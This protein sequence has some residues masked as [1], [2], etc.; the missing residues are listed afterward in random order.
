MANITHLSVGFVVMGTIKPPSTTCGRSAMG[1]SAMAAVLDETTVESK[2]PT[3]TALT[4]VVMST[5][6][7]SKNASGPPLNPNAKNAMLSS[8][9]H[10]ITQKNAS[11]KNLESK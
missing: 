7:S 4:E 11:R 1:V 8:S 5:A 9:V 3:A 10:W 2:S 6:S